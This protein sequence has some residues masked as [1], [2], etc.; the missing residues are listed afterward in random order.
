MPY[1][2]DGYQTQGRRRP[3]RHVDGQRRATIGND[4]AR[5][6]NGPNWL[7]PACQSALMARWSPGQTD[8]SGAISIETSA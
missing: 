3:A 6:D 2:Q 5:Y 8:Q 7:R 4:S 1:G